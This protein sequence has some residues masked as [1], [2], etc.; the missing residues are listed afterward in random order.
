ML[1]FRRSSNFL[2]KFKNIL[3]KQIIWKSSSFEE[4]SKTAKK[5]VAKKEAKPVK[6]TLTPIMYMDHDYKNCCVQAELP[7]VKK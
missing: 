2:F 4:G 5:K 3:R 6:I 1:L 7:N